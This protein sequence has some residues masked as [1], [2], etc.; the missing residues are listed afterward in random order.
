MKGRLLVLFFVLAGVA[1]AQFSGSRVVPRV[2][3]HVLTQGG[4]CVES[5]HVILMSS[6]GPVSQ[7]LTDAH[8][9]VDFLNVP[10]G[11]YHMN[12]SGEGYSTAESVDIGMSQRGPSEIEIEVKRPNEVD[13]NFA[14]AGSAFISA[15]DLAAPSRARKEVNKANELIS[16]QEFKEAMERLNKALAIY[17]SYA[18]AYNNMAVIYSRLHDRARERQALEK[19][20]S[21]NDHFALAIMNLG[22]MDLAAGDYANAETEL[23]KASIFVPDDPITL[24]LLAWVQLMEG[25]FDDAIAASQKAHLLNKPHEAA[26]RV[27]ARAFEK[28]R[29]GANAIAELELFVKES[30]PGPRADSAREEIE[31][32]KAWPR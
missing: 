14:A 1:L 2:R 13:R 11:N 25:H 26:H 4:G 12:V 28:K 27:A 22:R 10:E 9:V 24:I 29:Q 5:A 19:A 21:L 17:P 32:V 6:V 23:A 20:I 3:V 7:G 15:E 8:C 18:V 31:A 16:K 30:P